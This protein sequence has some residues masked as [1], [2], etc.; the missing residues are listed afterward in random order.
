[1][2]ADIQA[3]KD[4]VEQSKLVIQQETSRIE[5]KKKK[6]ELAYSVI[7]RAIQQDIDKIILYLTPKK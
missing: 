5:N 2:Q 3:N 6:F 1:M 4:K 7:V